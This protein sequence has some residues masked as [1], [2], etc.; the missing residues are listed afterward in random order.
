M[1]KYRT[2]SAGFCVC[3]CVCVCV[4]LGIKTKLGAPS[5]S[6]SFLSHCMY[7][8]FREKVPSSAVFFRCTE[9]QVC[10]HERK[11][12]CLSDS[13]ALCIRR[14]HVFGGRGGAVRIFVLK[15]GNGGHLNKTSIRTKNMLSELGQ[16]RCVSVFVCVR[17]GVVDGRSKAVARAKATLP[18]L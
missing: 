8:Y 16:V 15:V 17:A 5:L 10:P 9:H 14:I 12:N 11:N 1:R 6:L 13:S 7:M 18:W 2:S 4:C 3:V